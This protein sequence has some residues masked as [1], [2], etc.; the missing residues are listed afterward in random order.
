MVDMTELLVADP[1]VI[2]RQEL[3]KMRLLK[4]VV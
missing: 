4:T 3:S 1:C 2:D